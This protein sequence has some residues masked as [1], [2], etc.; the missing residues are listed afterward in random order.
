MT[1][2]QRRAQAADWLA[3]SIYY[4][5]LEAS[6]LPFEHWD[7]IPADER[8]ICRAAAVEALSFLTFNAPETLAESA[9]LDAIVSGLKAARES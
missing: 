9:E 8:L 7:E 2:P 1:T 6:G 5:H 4:A 3:R